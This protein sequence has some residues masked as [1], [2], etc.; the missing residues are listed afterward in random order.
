VLGSRP[1]QNVWVTAN[2]K[3]TQ[4]E[5]CG[6]AESRSEGGYLRED[7][8]RRWIPLRGRPDPAEPLPP[9]NATGNYVKSCSGYP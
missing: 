2:F 4:R 9:E 1:L 7:F 8:Q 5:T 3:E 6:P